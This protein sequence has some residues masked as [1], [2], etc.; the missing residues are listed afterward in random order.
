M[1]D[2][3]K[4]KLKATNNPNEAFNFS[5]IYCF[6]VPTPSNKDG[7]FSNEYL[8]RAIKPLAENLKQTK[9][10]KIFVITSTV[11][12]LSIQNEII[13]FIEKTSNKKFNKNFTVIYNPTFI[14][15]GDI[16]KGILEPDLVLIG[17]N[18]KKA[19]DVIENLWKKV[20]ENNPYVARMSIVSAEITKIAINSYITT[21]IS[22]ANMLGNICERIPGAEIDKITEAMGK[23]RRIGPYYFRYGTA[24]GGPCFPRDNKAFNHFA[25][26][27]AKI[28]ALIP[29]SAH[30]I[31]EFQTK[32]LGDKIL[33]ILKEKD[34]KSLTI[35]GLAYKPKTY[36][37][38]ESASIN[39]IKYLLKKNKNLKIT[40]Y[41]LIELAIEETKKVFKDKISYTYN[42]KEAIINKV[43]ILMLPDK[44]LKSKLPKSKIIVDCWRN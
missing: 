26:K 19:G 24:Y 5:D 10:F 7:S 41:D 8:K 4:N 37:I 43:L 15:I 31:N 6:I 29:L 40:V 39:L 22:F 28:D 33:N 9:N 23:D 34:I 20:C 13:P 30:K 11:S 12:P 32:F 35:L 25:K 3:S 27:F 2:K 1:I 14:A 42:L 38:E 18:N 21:K 16:I 36:V 17:E 44:N